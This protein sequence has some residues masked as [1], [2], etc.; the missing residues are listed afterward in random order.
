MD[1]L[2]PGLNLRPDLLAEG[3]TDTELRSLR[4][5][6]ALVT[7]R[8]GAYLGGSAPDDDA[9]RHLLAVR[10]AL[11]RL[12]CDVVVSHMSGAVLHGL[13]LWATRLD[14]VHVTRDHRSGGR[15]SGVVH[16]HAAALEAD[17]VVLVDGLPVT[18]VARTLVDLGRLLPFEPA[19]VP[20]DAAL[21]RRLTTPDAL[22]TA[23]DGS[24]HR[25]HNTAARRIVAF[26]DGLAESP[27]ETRSRVAIRRAGLPAPTLQYRVAGVRTDFA[28]EEFGTVGEFDGRVKYGRCLRPGQDPGDAVFAEKVREDVLR[29]DGLQVARWI[30]SEL[31]TFDAPAARIRRAFARR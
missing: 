18:S 30:W 10:A 27:G 28:W 24:A 7:V 25:P 3:V 20:A 16:L 6:G 14:R 1:P 2:R 8:P 11:P 22:A 15:R 21:R 31:D 5:R 23:I 9:A 17:E 12:G 29:D 26:A 4:R 19:L 13:P